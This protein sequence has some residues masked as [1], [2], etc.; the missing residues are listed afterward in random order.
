MQ[1]D[2]P[3]DQGFLRQRISK[4]HVGAMNYNIISQ[5]DYSAFVEFGTKSKVVIPA[6]LE[7]VAAQAKAST[8]FD[9][10][11]AKEAIFNWCQRQ[12]IDQKLWYPIYV[13]IM[14]NG[15]TPHPF[16]FAN[17]ER[18]KPGLLNRVQNILKIEGF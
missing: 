15:I 12:G 7:D 11:T 18:V 9:P 5:S 1:T 6:G 14:V 3:A 17:F 13:S 2:A 10:L 4:D 8:G 16:F